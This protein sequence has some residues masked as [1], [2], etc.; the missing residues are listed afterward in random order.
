MTPPGS[1]HRLGVVGLALALAFCVVV[2][3]GLY[4]KPF[5]GGGTTVRAQFANT[6][7]LHV[8]DQV[9][10]DGVSVGRV[11]DLQR[12]ADG[13]TVL[14]TMKLDD[15][16]GTVY[17]DATVAIRWKL[18]LGAAYYVGLDRGTVTTGPLGSAVIP[19]DRTSGQVELEDI[20]SIFGGGAR[21]GLQTLPKQLAVTFA[22]RRLPARPL[23]IFTRVAPSVTEGVGA[24]RGAQADRDLQALVAN[25][26]RALT[27]LDTPDDRLRVALGGL[28][29][30][31]ATTA[32][33]QA[34]IRDT[35]ARTPAVLQDTS[36]TL[37]RLDT[38]LDLAD[39]LV[40]RLTGP[41]PDVAP[42][43][44]ALRPT[45][46]GAQR[47]LGAARP[48]LANLRPAA[49]A[50]TIA[51]RKGLPLLNRAAPSVARFSDTILPY[52]GE[53]D[54]QT[55]HSASQMIGPALAGLGS[56]GAGQVDNASH[57]IRFPV[58][59]GSSSTYLPCQ[60]YFANP[61]A[62]QMVACESLDQILKRYLNY[63]PTGGEPPQS[64]RR[65]R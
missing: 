27:A 9:R 21:S 60:T 35:I 14:V 53:I 44:A 56:G 26:G 17:R 62:P 3:S 12:Q 38:T 31:V 15:Q 40:Q 64:R 34:D 16:A 59:F 7:Q 8:G 51:S 49:S 52:M 63:R 65:G 23:E 47:L 13:R 61:D 39:P 20:T 5:E 36:T 2:F 48:L 1:H 42:T 22:D 33:R 50:L 4:R 29:A 43:L 58:T 18:L 57:F 37:A 54:P 30:T 25:T 19:V 55:Q 10:V 45:L 28:A 32:G 6:Q 11:S 24:L 46:V 41:A